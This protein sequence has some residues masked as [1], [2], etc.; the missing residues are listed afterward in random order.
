MKNKSCKIDI[1]LCSEQNDIKKLDRNQYNIYVTF[2]KVY[3][4]SFD[5][6]KHIYKK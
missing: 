5:V 4:S 1:L 6:F 2:F 3:L